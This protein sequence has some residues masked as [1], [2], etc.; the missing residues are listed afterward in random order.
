MVRRTISW[1]LI[2]CA[3]ACGEGTS[4]SD[5]TLPPS[6][7]GG[8]DS[9]EDGGVVLAPPPENL[10][11]GTFRI[12][13]W[14][15]P[16]LAEL[17]RQRFDEMQA[18]GITTVS[19]ACEAS[20]NEP[21]Y[22]KKMLALAA[23]VGLTAIVS[24]SRIAAAVNG[25]D[26]AANL[27]AVTADYAREPGLAGYHVVDEPTAGAYPALATVVA[28]LAQRDGEHFG[29]V[30]L[31]PDYGPVGDYSKY[32]GD[33]L[34]VVKPKV[35]SW[36]YYPFLLG[37]ADMTSFFSTME[38][39][40]T[41][42]V[43]A[44]VP[45]WQFTQAISYTGHRAT[46]QAEKLWMGMQ[47]LAYGGAGISHFTYWTPPQTA[48]SFGSGIIDPAGK[49]TAQ[50]AEV[51]AIDAT[52]SAFG[53]Y[54]V[55]AKSTSV[56]HNGALASG[57]SPRPP[58]AAAYLPNAQPVT[59]GTFSLGEDVY[60]FLANRDY[61]RTVE[62]D[63]YLARAAG[64]SRLDV[65]S[66]RFVTAAP[67]SDPENV[68]A[69]GATKHHVSLPPADGALFHL[70]GP[71]S[72]GP[73]GAEIFVG[74]VRANAGSLDVV[75]ANFGGARLRDAGWDECPRGYGLLGHSFESNGFW[76]CV[77]NDLSARTFDVGNVV[78][79]QG[80]LYRVK[81][82]AVTAVGPAGWDTCPSGSKLLGRRFDNNGYWV[83][84]E[85]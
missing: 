31:L 72:A 16:P 45:F 37:G 82:G 44:G 52:L 33:F 70:R 64:A 81:A 42:A 26:V 41:H 47:T 34:S 32:V 84:L 17:T 53:R 35:L 9:M 68:G 21:A 63:V 25:T 24:D 73:L 65:A 57:T 59:V 40:R 39:V 55:R 74:T 2:L 69:G 8:A 62:T 10:P 51:T 30:N 85:P 54:L 7:D 3:G 71:V 14:C 11:T 80:T 75:D 50:Y 58:S 36:D 27:D 28:G 12:G 5:T 61:A 56:F 15:G 66:G 20:A 76:L 13:I 23:E 49:K 48:E 67:L 29:Y 4:S 60:V 1:A 38:T 46:N 83:C 79:G 22:N 18:A 77:R 19:N 6:R 78:G 43:A